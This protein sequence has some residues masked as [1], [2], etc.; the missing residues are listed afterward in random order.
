M[1]E[2]AGFDGPDALR[3]PPGCRRP[4]GAPEPSSGL[5]HVYAQMGRHA[6]ALRIIKDLEALSTTR[7][8]SP[9]GIASIYACMGE[10]DEGR[11]CMDRVLGR[12]PPSLPPVTLRPPGT[13]A[14]RL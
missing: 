5:A 2:G 1:A 7:Y 14:S 13:F 9:Y 11:C 10:V 6:E 3:R 8:V 4:K 12:P